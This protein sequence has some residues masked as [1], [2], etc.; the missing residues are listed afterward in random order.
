MGA[1]F[2]VRGPSETL[3]MGRYVPRV[4]GRG[5]WEQTGGGG[6]EAAEDGW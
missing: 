5:T 3:R 1:G 6:G 2:D 4:T